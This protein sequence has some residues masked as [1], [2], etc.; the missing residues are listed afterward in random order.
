MRVLALVLCLGAFA[1]GC[2]DETFEPPPQPDLWK[3]PYDFATV[4]D[5]GTPD[6]AV[7]DAGGDDLA[8]HPDLSAKADAAPDGG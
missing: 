7:P 4:R 3:Q 1:V 2:S 5:G 8:T 6:Q